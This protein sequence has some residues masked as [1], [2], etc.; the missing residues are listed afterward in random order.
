MIARL[1]GP[2]RFRW[3]LAGEGLS[4]EEVDEPVLSE[5][6]SLRVAGLWY[7]VG[8]QQ[9]RVSGFE[10]LLGDAERRLVHTEEHPVHVVEAFDHSA[11]A[12][13]PGS[14]MSRHDLAQ[15][16]AVQVQLGQ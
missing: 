15:P 5:E 9:Q 11:V 3:W 6:P 4:L 1:S 13:E 14:G 7:A 2:Q 12:H 8:E 16:A 10:H